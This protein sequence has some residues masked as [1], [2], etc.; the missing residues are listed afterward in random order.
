MYYIL[1]NTINVKY[2]KTCS[3]LHDQRSAGA[4]YNLI[5]SVLLLYSSSFKVVKIPMVQWTL[6]EN[7]NTH[8]YKFA[9]IY[10]RQEE[11]FSN[12]T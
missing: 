7:N 11:N 9:S 1:Y 6:H 12:N 5:D 3:G 2:L 8:K 4:D 10:M